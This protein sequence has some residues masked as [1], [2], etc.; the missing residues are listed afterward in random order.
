MSDEDIVKR[1]AALEGRVDPLVRKDSRALPILIGAI[2]VVLFVGLFAVYLHE[3]GKTNAALKERDIALAQIDKLNKQKQ[4]LLDALNSRTLTPA[5]RAAI[6]AELRVVADKTDTLAGGTQGPAGRDGIDGA[7]GLPG[8]DGRDGRP[9]PSGPPGKDGRDGTDGAN[10]QDGQPG[11]VGTPGPEGSPGAAGHDG[12]PPQSFSFT[13]Q[14][15]E[16][17]TCTDGD[18]DGEYTCTSDEPTPTPG[19]TLIP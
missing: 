6:V 2:L 13:T 16:H 15:G 19:P 14:D 10:G 4:P 3:N 8:R 12:Q 9:G 7:P 18:G 1:A 17:F 5:Q 11:P